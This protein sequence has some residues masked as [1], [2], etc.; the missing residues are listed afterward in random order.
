MIVDLS[1]QVQR[2]FDFTL[3]FLNYVTFMNIRV[4]TFNKSKILTYCCIN[5]Q[6]KTLLLKQ[7]TLCSLL[8]ARK[9]DIPHNHKKIEKE[10]KEEETKEY[11]TK[12]GIKK[13]HIDLEGNSGVKAAPVHEDVD[14]IAVP[15][16]KYIS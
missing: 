1:F 6:Y 8:Q 10:K 3:L 13:V 2:N 11:K 12:E 5:K 9:I 7:L 4:F 15:P 14:D 16:Q